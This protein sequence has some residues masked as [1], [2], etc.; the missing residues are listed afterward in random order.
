MFAYQCNR[1]LFSNKKKETID[2]HYYNMD[3]LQL[4][5]DWLQKPTVLLAKNGGLGCEW[6]VKTHSL[7]SPS[8]QS[9][10]G[11][12]AD[13]L[14]VWQTP[15]W[16]PW[17]GQAMVSTQPWLTGEQRMRG[18][19]PQKH[20]EKWKQ[21][22]LECV[23]YTHRQISRVWGLQAPSIWVKPKSPVTPTFKRLTGSCYEQMKIKSW[24]DTPGAAHCRGRDAGV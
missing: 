24:A 6:T 12:A 21:W 8:L 22:R 10:L 15:C 3:G 17:K 9:M 20:R 11:Q 23:P 4:C 2:T 16:R 13:E 7:T 1:I 19:D 5:C 18:N 14:K